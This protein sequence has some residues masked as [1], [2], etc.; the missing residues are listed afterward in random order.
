MIKAFTVV[1]D[2][3]GWRQITFAVHE[4]GSATV[5]TMT[6]PDL[7]V[8]ALEAFKLASYKWWTSQ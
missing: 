6:E 7:K 1:R 2:Q 4:D 5:D 3:G 8:L